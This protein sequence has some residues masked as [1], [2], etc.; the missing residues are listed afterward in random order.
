MKSRGKEAAASLVANSDRTVPDAQTRPVEGMPPHVQLIQMGV[1][2]WQA[3]ALYAAAELG[4]AD[5]LADGPRSVDEVALRT[6]THARSLFRLL[7][8][9]ASCGVLEETRN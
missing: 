6:G 4:V 9:L 2:I 1:A 7:R 8:A 5:I 3:R